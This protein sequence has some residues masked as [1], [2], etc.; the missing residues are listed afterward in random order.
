MSE[1]IKG[2][3]NY[4]KKIKAFKLRKGTGKDGK[5][6]LY[7]TFN[8]GNTNI[9]FY[10]NTFEDKK[11]GKVDEFWQGYYVPLEYP[12]P[13]AVAPKVAPVVDDLSGL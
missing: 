11:T 3:A 1:Q 10:K 12:K 13:G 9:V 4:E 2:T 7:G 6:Y 5:V 8:M